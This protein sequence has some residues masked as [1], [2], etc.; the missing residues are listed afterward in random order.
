LNV[1]KK[2]YP[3]LMD[4]NQIKYPID[5]KL[6]VKMPELHSNSTLKEPPTCKKVLLEPEDFENLLYIWEFFNNF[7]DFLSTPTFTLV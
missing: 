3:E 7:S 5:D 1:F 6:I 2:Y 4:K